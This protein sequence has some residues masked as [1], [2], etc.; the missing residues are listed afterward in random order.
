M[1]PAEFMSTTLPLTSKAAVRLSRSGS[2]PNPSFEP[3]FAGVPLVF[4]VPPVP[5]NA[6]QFQR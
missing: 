4:I 1:S 5:A 2:W 3:T 6:A